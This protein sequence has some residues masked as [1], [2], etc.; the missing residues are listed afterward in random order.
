MMCRLVI[1]STTTII[2]FLCFIGSYSIRGYKRRNHPLLLP[3]HHHLHHYQSNCHRNPDDPLIPHRR[4]SRNQHQPVHSTSLNISRLGD[5]ANPLL[6]S[7]Y[8]EMGRAFIIGQHIDVPNKRGGSQAT[9]GFNH[10]AAL[11]QQ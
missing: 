9:R 4:Q 8:T 7:N 6:S 10:P 2:C 3:S 1:T 11:K 5:W